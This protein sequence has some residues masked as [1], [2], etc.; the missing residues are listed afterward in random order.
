MV[1]QQWWLY[2]V[3]LNLVKTRPFNWSVKNNLLRLPSNTTGTLRTNCISAVICVEALIAQRQPGSLNRTS[4]SINCS[5][6]PVV[7][8]DRIAL[9]GAIEWRFMK[10]QRPS[11]S[12]PLLS[13]KLYEISLT[14]GRCLLVGAASLLLGLTSHCSYSYREITE[15]HCRFHGNHISCARAFVLCWMLSK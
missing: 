6:A 4:D 12:C 2:W 14:A 8:I 1:G 3:S 5:L 7:V 13:L 11:L 9:D 15:R 10:H